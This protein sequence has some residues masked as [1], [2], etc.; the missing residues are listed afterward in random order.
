VTDRP[1]LLD[2]RA[3]STYYGQ[4][5]AL[6]GLS[7]DV[8]AGEIVALLGANGAGKTTALRT[9]VGLLR[10]REGEIELDGE[11]IV[12]VP[13]HRLVA[14]G[15][16]L[17]PEGRHIFPNLTVRENL[18]MG[19]YAQA[20]AVAVSDAERLIYELFPVLKERPTQMGSNL[21]GGEQQ[22]LAI[23]RALMSQ[24]HLLLLDEPSLGLAP[25][26]V[27]TIFRVIRELAERGVTILLVEQNAREALRIAGRAYVLET[28]KLVH[29]GSSAE[30]MRDDA[31]QRVYLGVGRA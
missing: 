17:V 16:A 30:L 15:V 20:D 4:V 12:G 5:H 21:S 23:A 7:L 24:P 2:L 14:R 27:R 19:A 3:V 9:I 28:G 29:S 13:P 26:V 10:P 22:M 31:V 11:S 18:R 25:L 6:K 8:R 1:P